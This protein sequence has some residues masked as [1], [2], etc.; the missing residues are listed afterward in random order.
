M[1]PLKLT[2][3]AFGP[4]AGFQT[5]DF[6][7]LRERN[8]FLIHGPTG[9]GK[10]TIL[11]GIC[12]ALYGDTS[13]AERSGRSMRSHHAGVEQ[14]TEVT[15]EFALKKEQYRVHRKPE[16]ERLKK[17]GTGTTVQ[18][19]EA[20]LWKIDPSN[21]AEESLVE[22][23]W[24]NVTDAIEK[25]IGFKSSQFRQVIMLPQGQFRKLLMADS[26]ERQDI[27][28]K[29]FQT[30]MYRKIEELLK[31]SAKELRDSIKE[32]ENQRNWNLKKVECETS[33]ALCQMIDSDEAELIKLGESHKEK[34]DRVLAAQ[35][36]LVAGKAG[37]EKLIE[38]ENSQK[39]LK[40]LQDQKLSITKQEEVLKGAR[41]AAALEE[42]EKLTKQRSD[43]KIAL[44]KKLAVCE[45]E[46]EEAVRALEQ[47]EKLL[48]KEQGQGEIRE[49]AKAHLIQLESYRQKVA[50]LEAVKQQVAEQRKLVKQ[51]EDQK[52]KLLIELV[53][54]EESLNKQKQN[55]DYMKEAAGKVPLLEAQYKEIEKKYSQKKQLEEIEKLAAVQQ[56]DYIRCKE[57]FKGLDKK[58]LEH[59]NEWLRLQEAWNKGQASI[60]AAH[61]RANEACPVCGSTHHPK[62]AE[63]M[64][65]VPSEEQLKNS[66]LDLEKLEVLRE[67]SR[68]RLQQALIE[69]EKLENKRNL[70]RKE[71]EDPSLGDAAYL[72]EV[73]T[74]R[75]E[76][77]EK[78]QKELENLAETDKLL[79][80]LE[81]NVKTK[82]AILEDLLQNLKLQSES[83]R[84]IEGV[85]QE[86]EASIPEEIR[87]EEA[88]EKELK[89]T[90][91]FYDQLRLAL[92][93]AEKNYQ[94]KA[95]KLAAIKAS[96]ESL[97]KSYEETV[98]KYT[99][100]K[101]QF[102][103][104]MKQEG[105]Q[106]Y[107]D[108]IEAKKS[109]IQQQQIEEEIKQYNSRLG[110][111][112]ERFAR[113]V[114][115]AERITTVDLEQLQQAL[116]AAQKEKDNALTLEN[117]LR[118]KIEN[119]RKAMEEIRSLESTIQAK[120]ESYKVVGY[121]SQVSNGENIHG[122]T[123]QRF[124]LG[125][126]LDDITIAATE[127]LKRM[128]KGRYHLQRTLD[129]SRKNAAGGLELEVFDT[130]T[131]IERP[132]TTLSGGESFL[133]SLSLALGLADVVQSYS[134]GISLDTIFVDEGFGTLDPESL[135]FAL[136]AL[137]DLQQG[138]RLVGIISHVPELRERIDARLEVSVGEN[139]SFASFKIS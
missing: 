76:A 90:K 22:T 94:D 57:E 4:Y 133:A 74:K 14:M 30:E 44:E 10:T 67:K 27:M 31:K 79:Q 83:L 120:E 24:K 127:R 138:G 1:K 119:D 81:E 55:S 9:S 113:A 62:L 26:V 53:K 121:L 99:E 97:E 78:V 64:E 2:M 25:L 95:T 6:T 73:L 45:K 51:L 29:L 128:S 93:A 12:F 137:I 131:G 39:A 106:K 3:S 61:L 37:N 123:L 68:Q 103:E 130:Y 139:G 84:S 104:K 96:K 58:Y 122:L 115:V 80:T 40:L 135:D 126:L 82:K 23:G 107:A 75:K 66:A 111:A 91:G 86:R 54:M 65:G 38:L 5:L 112:E 36:A 125:A 105:F 132:V 118:K 71:L 21:T 20:I 59:K 136:K 124:V 70:L 114:K 116:I 87:S 110:A 16:Q 72:E 92:E 41:R 129:R 117:N 85:Y 89:K 100:E 48:H 19:A 46:T 13:G 108:Y 52:E 88:L 33:A 50:S 7:E 35:E 69:V 109:E 15:F 47:A 32:M 28:E 98:A 11:D 8:I 77:L 17:S 60:L 134:G 43:D 34:N 102:S 18:P 56:R 63:K 49:K 101:R 42:R